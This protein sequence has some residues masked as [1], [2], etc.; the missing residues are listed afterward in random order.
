MVLRR[1]ASAEIIF[2]NVRNC[3]R[4]NKCLNVTLV[5]LKASRLFFINTHIEFVAIYLAWDILYRFRNL[6]EAFYR[7]WLRIADEEAQHFELIRAHLQLLGLDY[8]DLPAHH[9]L[10]EHAVDTKGDVLARLAIVPRCLEAHG[11]DVTPSMLEKFNAN[12]DHAGAAILSRILT[13]EIGRVERGSFWFHHFCKMQN[14]NPEQHYKAL[15]ARYYKGGKPKGP[16][17]RELRIIA[18]FSNAELDWLEN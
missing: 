18:G 6:P 9:G 5:R 4:L 8:G 7:D 12:K 14:L 3:F 10:W 11:L 17:N 1:K 16:F 2:L 13:D 15:I